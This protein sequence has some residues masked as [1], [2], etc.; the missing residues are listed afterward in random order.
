MKSASHESHA[1][2]KC[3]T[4]DMGKA[5]FPALS[6]FVSR[7]SKSRLPSQFKS[8]RNEG[9]YIECL[10]SVSRRVTSFHRDP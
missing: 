6:E 4:F 5:Q 8:L 10:A 3:C 7:S 2:A 1:K 9:F